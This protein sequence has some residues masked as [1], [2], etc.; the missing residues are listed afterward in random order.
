MCRYQRARAL[1]LLEADFLRNW[2][3]KIIALHFSNDYFCAAV[4]KRV[5]VKLVDSPL[6]SLLTR[7]PL[8]EQHVFRPGK[9]NF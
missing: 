8:H 7:S 2:L 4:L 1:I 5:A 9:A 6:F 3:R